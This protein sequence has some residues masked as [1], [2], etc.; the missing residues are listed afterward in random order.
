[1]VGKIALVGGDE[2]L[3]SCRQMDNHL[4]EATGR[5]SPRVLIIPTAAAMERPGAGCAARSPAVR[6][7][8]GGCLAP[9]GCKS[10]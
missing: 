2:F 10:R 4:I 6:G 3:P 9:D 8:W 7:A 1:M 5:V